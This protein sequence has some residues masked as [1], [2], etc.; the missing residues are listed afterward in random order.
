LATT[1][2][3]AA[4]SLE[5]I[6][7]KLSPEAFYQSPGGRRTL[8]ALTMVAGMSK[9]AHVLDVQCGIGSASVDLA[10]AYDASVTAFDDYAPYLAFGKQQAA[11]RGVAKKTNF[12]LVA[13]KDASAA[14]PADSFD[15]VL[16]LGGGL[17]D[18]LPSGLTGGLSAAHEWLKSHGVLILGDLVTPGPTSDLMQFVF[19]NSLISEQEYLKAVEDAGFELILA[20]RSSSADWDQMASTMNRLR[21]R[22]LNLGPDDERQRQRLTTAA[23][24]HP[25]IAYLN[26]AARKTKR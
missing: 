5:S 6:V 13:G 20:V 1:R 22:A 24:N 25:E 15:V 16:G 8:I 7:A 3:A 19:G 21:E 10:E 23:R 17:S 18:T 2:D 12:Q 9:G 4:Q 26:V 11:S 14:I